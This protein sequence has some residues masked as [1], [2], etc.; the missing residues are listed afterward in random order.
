MERTPVRLRRVTSAGVTV[1]SGLFP[2]QWP[3]WREFD[4]V[5]RSSSGAVGCSSPVDYAKSV[6]EGPP[7]SA[8]GKRTYVFCLRRRG[9]LPSSVFC[10]PACDSANSGAHP[11]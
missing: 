5:K 11:G 7:R 4:R 6:G 2:H 1:S 10:P 3:A 9:R 8:A